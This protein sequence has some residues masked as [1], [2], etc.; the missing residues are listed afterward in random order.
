[1]IGIAS[2]VAFIISGF[3]FLILIIYKMGRL[4]EAVNNIFRIPPLEPDE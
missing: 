4:F 2:V 1:M 3:G